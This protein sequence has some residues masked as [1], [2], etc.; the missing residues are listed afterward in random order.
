[1]FVLLTASI[2]S[3]FGLLSTPELTQAPVASFTPVPVVIKKSQEAVL[4]PI[5]TVTP[6]PKPKPSSSPA[7]TN[8]P[9]HKPTPSQILILSPSPT[10]TPTPQIIYVSVKPISTPTPTPLPKPLEIIC[11]WNESADGDKTYNF[12]Q[13]KNYDKLTDPDSA[14]YKWEVS[15]FDP[16]KRSGTGILFS[17]YTSDAGI[18]NVNLSLGNQKT[19]CSA[20]AVT[21]T[22]TP[23]PL[24]PIPSTQSEFVSQMQSIAP[25]FLGS[26]DYCFDHY[27]N[28]ATFSSAKLLVIYQ[29]GSNSSE[30]RALNNDYKNLEAKSW[31]DQENDGSSTYDNCKG[32]YDI[33]RLNTN[34]LSYG[35]NTEKGTI[36]FQKLLI[37]YLKSK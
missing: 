25:M 12:F 7:L 24:L 31:A 11:S 6:T 18:Y 16:S 33:G 15:G 37:D 8:S 36:I 9:T 3:L 14:N 23:K 4:V 35:L 13:V 1:M 22:P 30:L 17:F 32:S 19:S 21:P 5:F 27:P 34:F 10:L 29:Y 28:T 2:G 26:V 20:W